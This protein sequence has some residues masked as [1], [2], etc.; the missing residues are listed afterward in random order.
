MKAQLRF[1]HTAFLY[2]VALTTIT[3]MAG[4]AEVNPPP[5][6]ISG[7]RFTNGQ[8]RLK[9]PYPAAQS[10][11]MLSATDPAGPYTPDTN[12]GRFLGARERD[13]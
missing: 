7:D 4:A 12:S 5:P 9:F 6:H 13:R 1:Y 3:T 10:Y 11:Q 8:P 2:L